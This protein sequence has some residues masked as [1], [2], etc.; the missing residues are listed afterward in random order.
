MEIQK[1]LKYLFSKNIVLF[2]EVKVKEQIQ[3]QQV[4]ESDYSSHDCQLIL[5][6]KLLNFQ[7]H[8][9]D[10]RFNFVHFLLL[11]FERL[12]L[13]HRFYTLA[14]AMSVRVL[15]TSPSLVALNVEPLLVYS[16]SEK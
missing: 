13:K 9:I 5:L 16:C 11:L 14:K 3:N 15:S 6:T 2:K 1:I 10:F 4:F 7:K 12:I 8:F